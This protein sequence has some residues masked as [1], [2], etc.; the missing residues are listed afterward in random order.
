MPSV[1]SS[2][3]RTPSS[4][5][6]TRR[7]V[8]HSRS[9]T[10]TGTRS[11]ARRTLRTALVSAL[12]LGV[13][14]NEDGAPLPQD[15]YSVR[16]ETDPAAT[17]SGRVVGRVAATR[18]R[19]SAQNVKSMRQVR[20]AHVQ[21]LILPPRRP[22][23][24]VVR[25]LKGLLAQETVRSLRLGAALW[26]TAEED[27]QK[28]WWDSYRQAL[29]D[30]EATGELPYEGGVSFIRRGHRE[31]QK[32]LP[33]GPVDPGSWDVLDSPGI[34]A[35]TFKIST[36]HSTVMS[37]EVEMTQVACTL[38]YA[39]DEWEERLGPHLPV[40]EVE[41]AILDNSRP[42]TS[43]P[44]APAAGPVPVKTVGLPRRGQ[45]RAIFTWIFGIV[46]AVIAAGISKAL[47]WI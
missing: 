13:A 14:R 1:R 20:I 23:T 19:F 17:L 26:D 33:L 41:A 39:V 30:Y 7:P 6:C 27:W 43:R 44:A 12:E 16:L 4:G 25:A 24:A 35:C 32:N 37:I 45:S 3:R 9:L 42:W 8:D 18:S 10:P 31:D 5:G 46:A 40:E 2:G 34:D 38:R 29:A 21:T 28:E 15:G 11:G 36:L 22:S 47:G